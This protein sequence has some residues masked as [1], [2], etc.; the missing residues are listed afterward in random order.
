[1][2]FR[3]IPFRRPESESVSEPKRPAASPPNAHAP[4]PRLADYVWGAR[5]PLPYAIPWLK[6]TL[7]APG[8]IIFTYIY[9]MLETAESKQIDFAN[10]LVI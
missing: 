9:I 5:L 10:L 7:W 3:R 8:K 1:M 4:V 2:C 6:P